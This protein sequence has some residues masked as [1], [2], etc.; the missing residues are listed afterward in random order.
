MTE[1]TAPEA[2][3]KLIEYHGLLKQILAA[4]DK[5][6]IEEA[7]RVLA[8]QV[9]YYERHYGKVPM[10]ETLASFHAEYPSNEQLGEL[11][12]GMETLLAVLMLATGV[13]DD[14]AGRA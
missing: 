8:A 6:A 7:A 2:L 9:G 14:T 4:A 1:R 13:A 12:Q 5:H 10:E 3:E 11:A